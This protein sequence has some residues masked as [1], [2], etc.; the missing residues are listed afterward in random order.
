MKNIFSTI[1]LTTILALS[2]STVLAGNKHYQ[3]KN[4][5]EDTARVTHVESLYRTV[6]V[7]TPQRE[8]W[9]EQQYRPNQNQHKS[10]TS[11]IAGSIVGGVVGNQFG[12]GS[13][14]KIMTVAGALLGGS[15]G[16]DY[17]H[18]NSQQHSNYNTVEQCRV[19]E[20]YHDEERSDGY[21]VTYRYNGQSYTTRMDHHPGKRIPVEVSVRPANNYY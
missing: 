19:T 9:Q 14:K 6:R 20:R 1:G 2:S 10:Y 17:N 13:G 5:F 21:R 3:S 7:S 16:R 8:C 18:N 15:V 4:H 12:G 11:T